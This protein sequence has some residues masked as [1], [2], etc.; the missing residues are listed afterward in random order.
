M[1]INI[2]LTVKMGGRAAVELILIPTARY[3]AAVL[4]ISYEEQHHLDR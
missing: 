1:K 4:R 3:L 2:I